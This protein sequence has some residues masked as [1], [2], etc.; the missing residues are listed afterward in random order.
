MATTVF[1]VRSSFDI[2]PII[3]FRQKHNGAELKAELFN[4]VSGNEVKL[5]HQF[6]YSYA[7]LDLTFLFPK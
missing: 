6:S 1:L 4:P 5:L 3:C 2:I 7:I